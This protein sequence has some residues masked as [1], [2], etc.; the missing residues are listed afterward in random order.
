MSSFLS[1]KILF[2]AKT[3]SDTRLNTLKNDLWRNLVFSHIKKDNFYR[4]N[5]LIFKNKGYGLKNYALVWKS[6]IYFT[7]AFI[8]YKELQFI[9][10]PSTWL[11]QSPAGLMYIAYGLVMLVHGN[12][13]VTTI[14]IGSIQLRQDLSVSMWMK[15]WLKC[16]ILTIAYSLNSVSVVTECIS[17]HNDANKCNT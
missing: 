1:F 15:S 12:I 7:K 14:T 6:L 3:S 16:I 5:A 9:D 8:P 11:T 10:W 2:W 17:D 4:S 13:Q